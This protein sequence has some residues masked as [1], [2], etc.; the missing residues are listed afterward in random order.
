MPCGR[1]PPYGGQPRC[2]VSRGGASSR[3]SYP[4][5]P[6]S[7]SE[8]RA[9]SSAVCERAESPGPILSEGKGMSAMSEVVGETKVPKPAARA[10]LWSGCSAA[11]AEARTRV[12]RGTASERSSRRTSHTALMPP[13]T[14][15]G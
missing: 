11:R 4:G 15:D 6:A 7:I 13:R 8:C 1:P 14:Y 12:E 5:I 3:V 2:S 9:Y 10:A